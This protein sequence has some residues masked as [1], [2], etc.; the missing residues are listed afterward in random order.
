MPTKKIKKTTP[1]PKPT[2]ITIYGEKWCPFCRE[3]KVIANAVTKRVQFVQGLS[4]EEIKKRAKLRSTPTTIPQIVVNG[5][6]IGGFSNL[7]RL[8]NRL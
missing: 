5:K 2:V 1:K 7:K 3:A 4:S 8:F 6:H